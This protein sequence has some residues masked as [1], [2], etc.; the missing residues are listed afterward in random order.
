MTIDYT[1]ISDLTFSLAHDEEA[2]ILV[3]GVVASGLISVKIEAGATYVIQS[4]LDSTES[5]KDYTQHSDGIWENI[6][7]DGVEYAELS[8]DINSAPFVSP[9]ILYIQNTSATQ[10]IKVSL[11]GNR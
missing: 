9:N 7:I 3:N 6:S 4:T 8:F 5:F 1:L 10:S 11:R 2:Y